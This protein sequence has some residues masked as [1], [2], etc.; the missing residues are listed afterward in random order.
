M[1]N[2][3]KSKL[4]AYRQCPKRL[5]LEIHNPGLREDTSATLAGFANGNKVGDIAQKLYDPKDKGYFVDREEVGITAALALST[6]LI[7]SSN[8]PVFEAGF[9]AAGAQAF[10]D[11]MLPARKAGKRVWHMVEVK[12]SASVKDYHR[13]DIAIQAFVARS[14]G[15]QLASVALAHIDSQWV[16]P[17]GGDYAGLLIEEDLTAEAFSREAEVKSW[18]KGAQTIAAKRKEPAITT[19]AQCVKPYACGFIDYCQSQEQQ[20]EY[21]VFPVHWLPKISTKKLKTYIED[22]NIDD[23]AEVPDELLNA[24]QLRV[25][26]ATL[27]DTPHFDSKGAAA[28]LAAYK[29]PAYFLD[30]E[31]ISIPVPVWKG[32]HPYQQMPFQFSLHRITRNGKL[33]HEA[34]LDLSGNDPTK[35]LA[36]ALISACGDRGPVFVYNSSFES[37]RIEELAIRFPRLR[38]ALLAINDRIVD[39]KPIAKQHYYHPDQCG[40]WSLKSILPCIASD[41]DYSALGE[42]RDGS[43][44]MNAYLEAIDSNSE[45]ADKKQIEQDLLDYCALDTYALV[46]IW[47]LFAGRKDLNL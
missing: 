16:Y 41:L 19:G 1:R 40:R 13:D 2:L 7:E 21:P 35:A 9:S 12:S 43:M 23:M 29:L 46:R 6:E 34:F 31:T 47:Q 26:Q 20:A 27:N 32:T 14:A 5:W 37:G 3:S 39:L 45:E 33:S 28:K 24:Q 22:E 44:A 11:V 10:A 8:A 4:I 18:I 15:V 17:G 42:V 36:E 25:K 38:R 30:F